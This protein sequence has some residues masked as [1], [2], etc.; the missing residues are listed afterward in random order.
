MN[1]KIEKPGLYTLRHPR[2]IDKPLIIDCDDVE[3]NLD[4]YSIFCVEKSCDFG[5]LI[6]ST[7]KNISITNGKISRCRIGIHAPFTDNLL[8]KNI[9]F[10]SCLYTGINIGGKNTSI[11]N[12]DFVLINGDKGEAYSIGINMSE[13]QNALIK[14]NNFY[15]IY[16]QFSSEP[17]M[18]GEGVGILLG[19]DTKNCII[20]DNY[21]G[22]TIYR[23]HTYGIWAAGENHTVNYNTIRNMQHGIHLRRSY[24]ENNEL[25][26]DEQYEDSKAFCGGMGVLKGNNVKNY[27]IHYWNNLQQNIPGT[28]PFRILEH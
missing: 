3:I 16:R 1:G 13:G 11:C 4:G 2:V 21:I 24:A 6:S 14:S 20:K 5:F 8:V 22:N 18:V 12:N 27:H 15:E 23:T 10:E 19:H 25:S 28:E 7:Y 17:D 9:Q 26:L